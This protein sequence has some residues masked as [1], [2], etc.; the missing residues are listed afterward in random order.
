MILPEN[1]AEFGFW[2]SLHRQQTAK[3]IG[4]IIF[5]WAK[6]HARCMLSALKSNCIIIYWSTKHSPFHGV[7]TVICPNMYAP[8][9]KRFTVFVQMQQDNWPVLCTVQHKHSYEIYFS[10]GRQKKRASSYYHWMLTLSDSRKCMNA[11]TETGKQIVRVTTI[12]KSLH[13]YCAGKF[14]V[15]PHQPRWKWMDL[16]LQF[17]GRNHLNV[18]TNKLDIHVIKNGNMREK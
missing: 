9:T 3:F 16:R 14:T 8:Y 12:N 1:C 4:V 18:R 10:G 13:I 6:Q 2:C 17:Y 7:G 11:Y 5:Y 15:F